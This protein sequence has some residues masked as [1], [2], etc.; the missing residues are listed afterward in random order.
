MRAAAH[1]NRPRGGQAA[2]VLCCDQPTGAV[3]STAGRALLQVLKDADEKLGATVL[4]VTHA[5]ARAAMADQAIRFT[6]SN[7]REVL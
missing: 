3:D 1:G 5:S 2:R 4:I 6:D 7:V